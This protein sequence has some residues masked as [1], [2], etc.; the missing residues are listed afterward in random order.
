MCLALF[1]IIWPHPD[2]L[3]IEDALHVELAQQP[4]R[5]FNAYWNIGIWASTT[6][7]AAE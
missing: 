4:A 6:E 1:L 5:V 2:R 3:G 7:R